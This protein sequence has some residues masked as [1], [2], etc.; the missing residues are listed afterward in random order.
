MITF[1]SLGSALLALLLLPS[2][3]AFADTAF[4]L[5]EHGRVDEAERSLRGV[6]AGEPGNAYAHQLLCRVYYAQ[7]K[8][9]QAV[10]ECEA[11]VAAAP[12]DSDD[13]MWLAR[14]YG[15]KASRSN[16]IAGYSLGKRVGQMFERAVRANPA[17][18]AALSDLGEFYVQAPR[19]VGGGLDK[20]RGL[21]GTMQALSPTKAHRMLAYIAAG[22]GDLNTAEREFKAAIEA[23]GKIPETY[24]DLAD[25]YRAHQ[26]LD[27]AVATVNAG[28]QADRRHGPEL[29]DAATILIEAK[30]AQDVAE[31]ALRDYLASSNQTDEAPVFKAHF[32]LGKLLARRGDTA[33]A[34]AEYAAALAL[35]A[36]FSPARDAMK[37][38]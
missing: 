6:L 2:S 24:M 1:H 14:A 3:A 7:Q 21:V 35:A 32:R 12:N 25:F 4:N 8:A 30:R 11:A 10:A 37:G 13:L 17:N 38:A 22:S 20:A 5:L 36:N 34:Q 19:I 33:G 29:M 16:P 9:D 23:S 28:I 26:R 31:R 18:V 27:E 15:Q